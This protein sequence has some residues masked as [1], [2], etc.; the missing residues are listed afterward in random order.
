MG[1]FDF[2]SVSQKIL[3]RDNVNHLLVAFNLIKFISIY[4]SMNEE[5]QLFVGLSAR[6]L[7]EYFK[8][9]HRVLEPFRTSTFYADTDDAPSQNSWGEQPKKSIKTGHGVFGDLTSFEKLFKIA[10]VRKILISFGL[11]RYIHIFDAMTDDQKLLVGALIEFLVDYF[12][13]GQSTN[14]EGVES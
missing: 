7:D 10:T 2:L 5:Q 6:L 11:E 4:E 14:K 3:V 1:A 12:K 8:Q 13:C 9:K